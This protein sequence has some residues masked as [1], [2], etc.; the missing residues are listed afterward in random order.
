MYKLI[1]YK[2]DPAAARS[3]ADS[4]V[5]IPLKARMFVLAFLCCVV[6]CR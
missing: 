4:R 5:R 6:L 2:A 3:E 1:N